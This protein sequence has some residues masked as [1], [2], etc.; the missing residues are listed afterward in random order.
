MRW[1]KKPPSAAEGGKSHIFIE[2]AKLLAMY[3]I[4]KPFSAVKKEKN[5][6]TQ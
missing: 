6:G 2:H 5:R 3:S 4:E 1:R